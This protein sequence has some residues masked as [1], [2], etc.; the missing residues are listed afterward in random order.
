M[1]HVRL[2]TPPQSRRW[3]QV[4]AAP[5]AGASASEI[6]RAS[7]DAAHG[8][9]ER[10]AKD[11]AFSDAFWLLA[12]L[13][14]AARSPGWIEN[15]RG[16]GLEISDAPTLIELAGA[17]TATLDREA[18]ARGVRADLGEM[19]R[20]SLVDCLTET[21]GPQLPGL[22]DPA[23]ADLRRALGRCASG[24]RFAGLAR[25]FFADLTRRTLDWHLSRELANHTGPER[26][27]ATDAQRRAFDEALATHCYET[28]RIVQE[29]L[30]GW[31]GKTAWR[32]GEL[33]REAAGRFAAVAFRKLRAELGRR[34][35]A[36]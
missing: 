11:P 19:A 6:A 4:V 34:Q 30:G 16:L 7:A 13:P 2:G 28:S 8:A 9:L 26:R 12:A 29:F 22:F 1:G 25:G 10:A 27:F 36:A 35:D 33:S 31:Y 14:M 18:A 3:R 24:D 15:L 17:L 21:L 23:P 32:D 20:L 5:G